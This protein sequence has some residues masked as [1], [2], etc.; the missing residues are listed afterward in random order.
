MFLSY[1]KGKE[2]F[3]KC[4][5]TEGKVIDQIR[6]PQPTRTGSTDVWRPQ[7]IFPVGDTSYI[8]T[9]DHTV[10]DNGE[11]VDVLYH[12]DSPRYAKVYTL[13]FWVDL[14]IIIPFFLVGSFVFTIIWITVTNYGK[15]PVI[16]KGEFD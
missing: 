3:D 8:F 11:I 13:G 16:L 1:K 4:N 7:I 5:L 10:F 9:D 6:L 14:G 2:E 15:K 12:K